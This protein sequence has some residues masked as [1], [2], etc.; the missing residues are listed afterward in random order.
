MGVKRDG[1]IVAA[2]AM[3]A[4]EGGAFPGAIVGAGGLCLL[5]P[6]NIENFVIDMYDVVV[7]KPKTAAYRAPGAPNSE[8]AT[9][10]MIDEFCDLLKMDPLEF[11]FKN[12]AKEGDVQANDV[13]YPRIGFIETLEAARASEHYRSKLTGPNRGRGVAGWILD[14]RRPHLQRRRKAQL[15]RH[16]HFGRGLHRHRRNTNLSGDATGGVARHPR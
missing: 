7:N 6:Y 10:A 15:R 9:E 3:L 12:A 8:H 2:E 5:A 13:R 14:E 1:R 4:Y 11:R 16:R